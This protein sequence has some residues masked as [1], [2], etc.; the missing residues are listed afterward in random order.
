M[1]EAGVGKARAIADAGHAIVVARNVAAARAVEHALAAHRIDEFDR[2]DETDGQHDGIDRDLGARTQA[3]A[4]DP[5]DAADGFG[6]CVFE[7]ERDLRGADRLGQRVLSLRRGAD[8][9]DTSDINALVP[10]Q[11]RS[12]ERKVMAADD[13]DALARKGFVMREQALQRGGAHHARLVPAR[14]ADGEITRAGG[15]DEFVVADDPAAILVG[16]RDD[17][18]RQTRDPRPIAI[19]APGTGAEEDL[20]ACPHRGFK[21]RLAHEH[22]FEHAVGILRRGGHAAAE[23]QRHVVAHGGARNG[24][25]IDEKDRLALPCPGKRRGESCRTSADDDH[26][27][28]RLGRRELGADRVGIGSVIQV[29][30]SDSL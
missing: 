6:R 2:R 19:D 28:A 25:F 17:V 20:D 8:L 1:V 14:K 3:D 21:H 22:R 26:V 29:H 15:K 18:F 30:D 24:V 9:D 5:V 23:E 27:I 12:F 11:Q 10:R 7:I 13:Q 16:Q 4:L